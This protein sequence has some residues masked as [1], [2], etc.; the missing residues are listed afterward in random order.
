M[1]IFL[2][3]YSLTNHC[4]HSLCL[5]TALIPIL[6][7]S[8][9]TYAMSTE[10]QISNVLYAICWLLAG[11]V[12]AFDI[13]L[14]TTYLHAIPSVW[15]AVLL[16]ISYLVRLLIFEQYLLPWIALT[17]LPVSSRSPRHIALPS[18]PDL[19]SHTRAWEWWWLDD[20]S[21]RRKR[22]R[23]STWYA[24][25]AVR[26]LE[27]RASLVK[28]TRAG[29]SLRVHTSFLFFISFHPLMHVILIV[30]FALFIAFPS[31]SLTSIVPYPSSH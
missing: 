31:I 12:I 11:V 25:A 4:G 21:P 6:K 18:V 13:F 1:M 17:L 23:A 20:T 29:P 7:L 24:I 16:G 28:Q 2:Y 14:F 22:W 9:S 15:I 30:S 26:T 10:F 5:P 27:N 8:S 3:Q 19:A